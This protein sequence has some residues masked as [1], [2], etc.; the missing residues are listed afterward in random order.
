MGDRNSYMRKYAK[1]YRAE[2]PEYVQKSNQR[3]A[4]NR[5]KVKTEVLTHYGYDGRLLCCW[6]DCL[7]EDVDV[8]TLDH[9][10]DDGAAH[11]SEITGGKYRCGGGMNIYYWVK[12]NGYPQGFQTLCHNHQWKKEILRRRNTVGMVG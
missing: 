2:H 12:K 3:G 1:T 9:L 5:L 11:R 6:E 8:L 7:I 4:A 10:L